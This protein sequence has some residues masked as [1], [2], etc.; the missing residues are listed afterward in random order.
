MAKNTN[1]DY[2][3]GMSFYNKW[4]E[5]FVVEE[6]KSVT[7]ILV[8]FD[9][10]DKLISATHIRT[11]KNRTELKHP[12]TRSV[13]NLGYSGYT[14]EEGLALKVCKK[15][16]SMW[17]TIIRRWNKENKVE[18]EKYCSLKNFIHD[19]RNLKRYDALISTTDKYVLGLDENGMLQIKR[20]K[21]NRPCKRVHSSGKTATFATVEE[22]ANAL[23]VE[24]RT[25][26]NYIESGKTFRNYTFQWLED[27]SY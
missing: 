17:T 26:I 25:V 1:Y 9:N 11:L 15:E 14:K 22:C 2:F 7:K 4:N 5:I 24:T 6:V 10:Y 18:N 16:R 13:Y 3:K 21:K 19:L 27:K 12:Y 20:V 8:K 23:G